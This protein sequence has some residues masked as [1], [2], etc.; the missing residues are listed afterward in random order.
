MK[1]CHNVQN[2]GGFCKVLGCLLISN[3]MTT[4]RHDE[5]PLRIS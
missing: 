3:K 5:L 4:R 1:L 2:F